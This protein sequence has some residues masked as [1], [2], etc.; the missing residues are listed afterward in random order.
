MKSEVKKYQVKVFIMPRQC[1]SIKSTRNR[2][3]NLEAYLTKD[4]RERLQKKCLNF[5]STTFR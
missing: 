2:I 5:I 4:L 3:V 1:E